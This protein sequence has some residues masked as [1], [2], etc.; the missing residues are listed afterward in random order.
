MRIALIQHGNW[1]EGMGWSLLFLVS[2]RRRCWVLEG[3]SWTGAPCS[4]RVSAWLSPHSSPFAS[5]QPLHSFSLLSTDGTQVTPGAH[6]PRPP[7][8]GKHRS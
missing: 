1:R 4:G 2:C 5:L 3:S 6:C 8:T 7:G